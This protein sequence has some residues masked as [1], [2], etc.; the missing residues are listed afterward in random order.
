MGIIDDARWMDSI[1]DRNLTSHNYDDQTAQSILCAIINVY[2]LLFNAFEKKCFLFLVCKF[3][4]MPYGLKETELSKL[5]EIFASNERV[6]RVILYGSRAKGCHKPFS[7]VD[8]TLEGPDL[9]R[10]DL[11][12]ISLAIDDLI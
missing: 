11:S 3:F 9:T 4:V 8:I 5:T 10:T 1:K 7:D 2:A 6:E 12:R